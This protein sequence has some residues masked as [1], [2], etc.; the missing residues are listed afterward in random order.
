MVNSRIKKNRS[1][2]RLWRRRSATITWCVKTQEHEKLIKRDNKGKSPLEHF[3]HHL[4][5]CPGINRPHSPASLPL[6]S[7]PSCVTVSLHL[8]VCLSHL[9]PIMFALH[10]RFALPLFYSAPVPRWVVCCH[11][12]AVRLPEAD[13]LPSGDVQ[14][15]RRGVERTSSSLMQFWHGALADGTSC[16]RKTTT[17]HN[18]K[19]LLTHLLPLRCSS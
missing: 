9:F 15:R 4:E 18:R 14:G 8:S 10:C 1:I 7:L 13:P 5:L 17:H 11:V 12:G 6:P 2:R 3:K 16:R 19:A